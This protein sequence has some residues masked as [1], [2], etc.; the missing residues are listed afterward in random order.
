MADLLEQAAG[1]LAD[2]R[3][4]NLSRTV[5]YCR[6]GLTVQVAATAGRTTFELEDST[7]VV[8][9]LESRDFLV[10]ADKLVLG[11]ET[12][13][14][15]AGDRVREPVGAQTGGRMAG[16]VMVYEVLAPGGED[17]WRFG[18]AYRRTLR[19]H[20]KLVAVE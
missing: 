1:W 3:E 13:L 17:C 10:S 20:T 2:V 12:V 19:I 11:G 4:A 7:G 15:Q 9:R 18:D 6:A 16:Q 14:P 8:H 5:E